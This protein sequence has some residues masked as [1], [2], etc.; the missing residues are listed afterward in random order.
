[1]LNHIKELRE[2]T[3]L[4]ISD[5]K[6][7]VEA[8]SASGE[9]DKDKAV[10]WLKLSGMLKAV[11]LET[12]KRDA[13]II[14]A[15]IHHDKS[16][17]VL[18]KITC[19]T[20]FVARNEEFIALANNICLHIVAASPLYI[21]IA[22][23]DPNLAAGWKEVCTASISPKV[24]EAKKATV[25]EG[26]LDKTYY[27]QYVLMEQPYILEPKFKVKDIIKQKSAAFGESIAVEFFAKQTVGRD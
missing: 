1:M 20:D 25:L 18:L 2:L 3:F 24:P 15:Y 6:A 8:V 27:Q 4:S 9:Y 14:H 10:E 26:M 22:D 7:A 16:I 12:R 13:G 19:E 11:K 17:G 23:V 5:C 21:D